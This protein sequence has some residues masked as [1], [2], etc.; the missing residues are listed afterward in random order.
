MSKKTPLEIVKEKFGSKE[1]LV[2]KL[3]DLVEPDEDESR[4]ELAARL[5]HVANAKLL[6]LAEVGEK[7]K[8]MGGKEK[9]AEKVAELRGQIK[10][11]DYVKKAKSFS[12]SKLMDMYESLSK[13]KTT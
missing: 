10:D 2:H 4:E 9:L 7:V 13:K 5:K 1:E 3:L 6:H 11:N 12:M 8:G